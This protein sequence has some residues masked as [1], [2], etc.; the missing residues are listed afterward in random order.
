M[1][2]MPAILDRLHHNA[3]AI[4]ALASGVDDEQARWRP[5]VGEW[6]ILEVVCHLYDEEREDFRTR[7]DLILHH[8]DAP[9]PPIDP[10]GWV[11]ARGYHQRDLA[12][13]L[14]AFQSERTASLAWLAGLDAP[15]WQAVA[16]HPVIGPRY[17]GEMMAS[18]LA[19]DCLHLRQLAQLHHQYIQAQAQPYRVEYAGEW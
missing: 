2:E 1:L 11:T 5:A 17:A 9:W 10:Q 12:T 13:E 6:S 8:P 16:V 7:L 18:W 15:N 4:A 14:A 3:A 19:H